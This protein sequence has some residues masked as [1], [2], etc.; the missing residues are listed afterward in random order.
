MTQE[1]RSQTLGHSGTE[2]QV[3]LG[4]RNERSFW[5][6][7]RRKYHQNGRLGMGGGWGDGKK[8]I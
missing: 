1:G 3:T 7:K 5:S 2:W 6:S 4:G 8:R